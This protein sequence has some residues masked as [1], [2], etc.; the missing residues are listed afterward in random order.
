MYV[1]GGELG[2][3]RERRGGRFVIVDERGVPITDGET[4]ERVRALRIPPAWTDVWI[5]A[6][7]NSHLQATG[8]DT[9]GR[10]QYLYHPLW[11]LRRDEE[12]FDDM[13]EFAAHLPG[14]RAVARRLLCSDEADRQRTLALAIRLLD[15]GFF[16]IG[17]DRYA[18]DNGHVGLTTL[19]RENVTLQGVD[20]RFDFIAKS[21]KR[22]RMTVRDQQSVRVLAD[23]KRRRGA[24][25]ELLVY[26]ARRSWHRIH[27]ADVNNALRCWGG[28]PYSAKEFR[29]WSATVLAAAALAREHAAG[30]RGPRAVSRAVREVS[31]ALGNT[32][33]VARSSYIH[34]RVIELFEEGVVMELPEGLSPSAVP[35]RIEAASDEVVIELPTDVDED[36][37]RLDVEHRVHELLVGAG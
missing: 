12:K 25:H 26:P 17:W 2:L 9:K 10:R 15:I 5:S 20:V 4:L 16:R 14:V 28:G 19:R 29:T 8:L 11:R 27:A 23:L 6:A 7:A 13:L 24:P 22:R 1:H 18:R 34:P 31:G 33:A 35:A 3:R 21:G 37:I 32:P 30:Q 36:A